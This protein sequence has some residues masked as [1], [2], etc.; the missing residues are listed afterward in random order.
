MEEAADSDMLARDEVETP[1]VAFFGDGR[2]GSKGDRVSPVV[3][4]TQYE[5]V[6]VD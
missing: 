6:P 4:G 2:I 5:T 3:R 1:R